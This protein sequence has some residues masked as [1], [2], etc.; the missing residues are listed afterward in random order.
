MLH[1]ISSNWDFYEIFEILSDRAG[2]KLIDQN[3][4][5]ITN[6]IKILI[7]NFHYD[8]IMPNIGCVVQ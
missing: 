5:L 2:F 8:L 4:R 7:V 6:L 3:Q 1:K